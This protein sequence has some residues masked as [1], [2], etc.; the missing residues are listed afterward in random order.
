MPHY[1]LQVSYTPEAW[2]AMAKDP[3][4]RVEKVRP[5]VEKLGGKLEQ[6]WLCFGEY[7]LV[8]ILDMPDDVTMAGAAM[9]F[10]AGGAVKSQRTT[11]LMSTADGVEAMRKAGGAAYRP[12]GS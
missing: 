3:Q 2:A 8:A 9:A 12:P 6:G 5:A 1:L 11:P 10:A 7:D 4:D